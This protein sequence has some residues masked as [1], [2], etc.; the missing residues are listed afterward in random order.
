MPAAGVPL[1]VPVPPVP[2]NVRPIGSLPLSVT[3]VVVGI[4]GKVPIW[5]L[6]DVPTVNVLLPVGVLNVGARSTIKVKV[7]WI[8]FTVGT[9][10]MRTELVALRM[11]L[12]AGPAAG[13]VP[14]MLAVPLPLSWKTSQLGSVGTVALRATTAPDTVAFLLN[15][16]EF[17]PRL[18]IVVPAGMPAP[19]TVCPTRRLARFE[20]LLMV[21]LLAVTFPVKPVSAVRESCGGGMAVGFHRE[22]PGRPSAK[23]VRC[24]LVK[25][26]G[27]STI[28][29]ER[30]R[31]LRR[32]RAGGSEREL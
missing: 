31:R 27:W 25:A 30:L 5:Y 1:M 8:V 10:L 28:R 16:M 14:L 12:S 20:T 24:A 2:E 7:C 13:G 22:D 11:N 15:V 23:M 26:G 9:P 3:V 17:V 21:K 29:H 18:A 4:P 19:V 6:P 32:G